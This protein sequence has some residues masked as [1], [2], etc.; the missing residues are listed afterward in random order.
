M[1]AGEPEEEPEEDP[2]EGPEEEPMEE[3]E[4][5]PEEEMAF[6]GAEPEVMNIVAD[7]GDV[8]PP[9]YET[10][11]GAYLMSSIPPGG[12]PPFAPR[13]LANYRSLV[14]PEYLRP[15]PPPE[16]DMELYE[17]PITW[18]MPPPVAVLKNPPPTLVPVPLVQNF[19]E[20][21]DYLMFD[22]ELEVAILNL[23]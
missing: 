19:E 4:E 8:P 18:E 11:I 21:N 5:D 23:T 17:V 6:L 9:P 2:E 13:V 12:H 10:D 3:P 20:P 15:T 22:P 14:A 1:I 7:S 16:D